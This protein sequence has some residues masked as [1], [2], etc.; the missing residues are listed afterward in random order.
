MSVLSPDFDDYVFFCKWLIIKLVL[1]KIC[2]YWT[3]FGLGSKTLSFRGEN[4]RLGYCLFC[5]S[6][7]QVTVFI[8]CYIDLN[9]LLFVL[10]D[11]HIRSTTLKRTT[12]HFEFKC[13]FFN[14][15]ERN[16]DINFNVFI[17][18]SVSMDALGL[19]KNKKFCQNTNHRWSLMGPIVRLTFQTHTTTTTI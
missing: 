19:N 13:V 7:L 14:T 4:V 10:F 3:T 1:Y 5:L 18:S 8:H 15:C 17:I 12:R 6:W 11:A 16:N 9:K 2:C